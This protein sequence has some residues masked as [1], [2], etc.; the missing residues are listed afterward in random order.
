MN[1][2]RRFVVCFAVVLLVC[3]S[4][5][6]IELQSPLTDSLTFDESLK[7]LYDIT[8]PDSANHFWAIIN[9]FN[10]QAQKG[11]ILYGMRYD[12]E[13]YF[14]KTE[15]G[16]KY[17]PEKIF[18]Q[19]DKRHWD[20]RLGDSYSLLGR[21]LTYSILKSDQ[22]GEDSTLQGALANLKTTYIN[23][24]ALGGWVNQSDSLDFSPERARQEE[25]PYGDR[26]VLYGGGLTTGHPSYAVVGGNYIRGHL[27]F[28]DDETQ[29]AE[30]EDDDVIQLISA[31]FEAPYF[32]YGDFYGE[33]A[34]L[35][36]QDGRR[37]LDDKEYEGRGAYAGLTLYYG[38][39][40]L[41]GEYKDYFLFDFQYHEPPSL[42]NSK[43]AFTHAPRTDDI[44]GERG[45]FDFMIPKI[46]TLF[47]TAYYQSTTH[48]E[49]DPPTDLA[50]HYSGEGW[51][52]W[53]QHGYG[54]IEKI[55][56]NAAFVFGSG[57]YRANLEGRWIHGEVDA[58]YPVADGHQVSVSVHM[59]QFA[60]LVP[61]SSDVI[62]GAQ[63]YQIEYAFSP[64]LIV[65]AVYENSD[66][67][68]A[69]GANAE[70]NPDPHFY[71]GQ[72]A[73]EPNQHVRIGLFYGRE[74]GGLQCAGGL[75]RTVPPFEGGR[76]DLQLRF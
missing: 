35:E 38:P 46:D 25:T 51:M 76:M 75:C 32:V 50:G 43:I 71:S 73:I 49:A 62:Y 34:W 58:G 47:Y 56:S 3:S 22:F 52:R 41:T 69:G 11:D 10:I 63:Y 45:Q 74:K 15:F 67:P 14:E 20:L 33:Y 72:I 57:G 40:T 64:L 27:P 9:R 16:I 31:T 1:P 36:Y 37:Q 53:I 23:I 4:A 18:F 29:I 12:I 44:I 5:F 54:G 70:E 48:D 60:Q 39:V 24:R 26:D 30:F 65:T 8:D 6:A 2:F 21:G 28:V 19:I 68:V 59:K 13:A 17:V 66:E 42:E 61:A 7:V 55:F